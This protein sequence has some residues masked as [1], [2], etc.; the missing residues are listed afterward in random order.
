LV[1]N[2]LSPRERAGVRVFMLFIL[3]LLP[4]GEGTIQ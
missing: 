1:K 4:E 3:F 2:S